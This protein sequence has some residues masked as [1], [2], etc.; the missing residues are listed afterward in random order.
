MDELS[1]ILKHEEDN[2]NRLFLVEEKNKQE[3][4]Q[5]E[6]ELKEKLTRESVLT[7]LEKNDLLNNK[8]VEIK[9]IE[10]DVEEK[11]QGKLK[12][13]EKIDKKKALEYIIKSLLKN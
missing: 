13:L 7:E 2:K 12:K 8:K 3:L 9:R 10:Q 4:E 11:L 1:Q 5:K 6:K